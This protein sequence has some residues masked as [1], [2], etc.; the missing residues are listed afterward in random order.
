MGM[1]IVDSSLWIEYLA[2][3]PAGRVVAGVIRDID[4]L[5]VPTV[6]IYEVYKKLLYEKNMEDAIYT[7]GQMAHGKVTGFNKKMAMYAAQISKNHKLSVA[8][9]IIYATTLQ[10]KGWTQDEHF[11]GMPSVNY[12]PK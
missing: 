1:N 11:K 2:N 8:D 3:T 7:T 5:V 10:Y 9:S 4:A 6:V 12:F